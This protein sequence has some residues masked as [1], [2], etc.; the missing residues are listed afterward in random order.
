L[1]D[2]P[3]AVPLDELEPIVQDLLRLHQASAPAR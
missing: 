3:N 2:G 1:S